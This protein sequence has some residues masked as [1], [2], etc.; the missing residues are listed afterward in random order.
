VRGDEGVINMTDD[1]TDT[2]CVRTADGLITWKTQVS[3]SGMGSAWGAE[4]EEDE[5]G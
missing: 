5:N 3:V 2:A 1:D 4:D